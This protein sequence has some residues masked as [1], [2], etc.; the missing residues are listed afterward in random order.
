VIVG[1]VLLTSSG[2]DLQGAARRYVEAWT[3]RDFAR[4]YTLLDRASRQRLTQAQFVARYRSAAQTATL[5]SL[6]IRSVG[7]PSGG[8]VPVSM[9]VHTAVFGT[10]RETLLVPYDSAGP[11]PTIRFASTLLF[12]G[13]RAGEQL[14]RTASLPP[15]GAIL[16]RNGVPLAEGPL[17]TS[18]IPSVAGEIVGTLG[19]IPPAEK[20]MYASLGYPPGAKVGLDG[21]ERVFQTELAGRPGGTLRAGARVLASAGPIPGRTVRST[22]DP[23]M[24]AAAITALAGRYGGI[25]A[26]DPRNGQLLALAGLAY[27]A[28]QPPGSTMKIITSSAALQAG[29]VKL[30]DTFPIA[31]AAVVGGY[32]LHNAGGEACGG[33]LLNA[34]AVSCN[35]VFAP[36]GVRVGGPRLVAM[37]ERFGFNQP[38]NIPGAAESTIPSAKQIGGATAV[39]SSAIGQGQVQ[40]S[41]LE[42]TDA[43]AT[44]AMGGRRP[45][46]TLS[47]G[48][49]PRFVPVTSSHVAALV[50]RMM[51]AVVQYGTGTAAQIPGVAVAG[52]TG[53]AEVVTS[54]TPTSSNPQ[55]ADAWFVGYAPAGAPRIVAGA[56]FANQGYGGATAAPA[57]RDVLVAGLQR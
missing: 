43:A 39:G 35:S 12:P 52:K 51:I 32:T 56:L 57:V 9:R 14:L 15:R 40:A 13:L 3:R 10:L 38:V 4:M 20:A 6:V 5:R 25:V 23:N 27:S 37:A 1:T 7:S 29:I 49:P 19:P 8:V 42:M 55:N 31:T 41:T 50:Q 34:F 53:T 45:L 30:T 46:P 21:L 16:A 36:L 33:T 2:P 22:I 26:M 28:L 47:M 18:P 11:A 48:Q 24:E 17:R 54:S 44:I